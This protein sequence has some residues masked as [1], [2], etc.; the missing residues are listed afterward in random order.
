MLDLTKFNHEKG[1]FLAIVEH[2]SLFGSNFITIFVS[3]Q[4]GLN[5]LLVPK[6]IVHEF[7]I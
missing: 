5:I 4:W 2:T 3:W 6:S 1:L 7:L